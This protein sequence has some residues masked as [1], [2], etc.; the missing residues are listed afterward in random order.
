[1]LLFL[2][3]IVCLQQVASEDGPEP[4]PHRIPVALP[5][6]QLLPLVQVGGALVEP[7]S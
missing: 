3:P 7:W 2:V 4:S 6:P 1:M 5:Y